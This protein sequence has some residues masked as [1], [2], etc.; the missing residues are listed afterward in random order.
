MWQ[1]Y[2]TKISILGI[3]FGPRLAY[4]TDAVIIFFEMA[5]LR[6]KLL[7]RLPVQWSSFSEYPCTR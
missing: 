6:A 5:T 1:R 2:A 4:I 7:P 3:R